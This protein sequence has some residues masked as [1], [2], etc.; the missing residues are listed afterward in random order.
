MGLN[1][2]TMEELKCEMCEKTMTEK[3]HDFC[4]I[5]PECLEDMD[6]D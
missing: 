1:N 2:T 3:D 4:D 5:C 6:Y